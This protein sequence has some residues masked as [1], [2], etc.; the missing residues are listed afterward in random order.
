MKRALPLA[1]VLV[2]ALAAAACGGD[3]DSG[4]VSSDSDERTIEIEMRDIA[5]SPDEIDVKV[6]ETIR[7]VFENTGAVKH[8]AYVGD[9]DAQMQH[10]EEMGEMGDESTTTMAHGGGG[11]SDDAITVDSGDSG[12]LTYTFDKAGTVLVGC[13]EPGHYDAGMVITV[14]VS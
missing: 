2:L 14:N 6:G 1:T 4:T 3:D 12:E 11:G 8:D 10:E 13:H 7:F 5:Y 9:E